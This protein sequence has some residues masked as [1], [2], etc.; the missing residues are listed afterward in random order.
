MTGTTYYDAAAETMPPTARAEYYRDQIR[1]IV[2]YAYDNAPAIRRQMDRAGV[3]PDDI[4]GPADLSRIPI[5][6]KS[7][8]PELQRQDYPFGGFLG[9]KNTKQIYCSP[10]PIY[11]PEI[12]Q[13]Q[14]HAAAK[15]LY[16]TG[17]REGDCAMIT[18]SFHMVPAGQH[19]A[20]AMA[21]MGVTMVPT[22]V[23]NTELQL[24]IMRDLQIDGYAGTPSFLMNLIDKA[25]ELGQDFKRDYNLKH[26]LVGAEM[27]PES[28]RNTFQDKYGIHTRQIFSTAEL[29]L[30]GYECEEKSGWHVPEEVFIEI[31]DPETGQPVPPGEVGEVVVTPFNEIFP[32]VRYAIGDL[33]RIEYGACPCGRTSP[34]LM[35]LLG[36]IG[37][38]VKV[39]AMFVHGS[40]VKAVIGKFDRIAAAQ[41]RI[42]RDRQ[43]DTVVL[44]CE[45]KDGGADTTGIAEDIK[46][47]FPDICRVKLDRVEFVDQGTLAPDA[48]PIIDQRQWD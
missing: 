26:A 40:Q 41:C 13:C 31:V 11:E 29:L 33:S 2:R 22:G 3:S 47:A 34:K 28:L 6:H 25:E 45:L 38:A 7:E 12:P 43:R 20:G 19:F 16:A 17:F 15:A 39:R 42:G 46:A 5:T 35:G 23:G 37:D 32:L 21:E 8:F 10:G 36:R 18:V 30:L 44:V 27:L 4:H 1:Q 24:Q 9:V 48:K 14:Y